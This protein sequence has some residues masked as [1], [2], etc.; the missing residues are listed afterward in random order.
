MHRI[1]FFAQIKWAHG[2]PEMIAELLPKYRQEAYHID[3]SFAKE[4]LAE[5]AGEDDTSIGSSTS[6]GGSSLVSKL[7][8]LVAQAST[9]TEWKPNYKLKVVERAKLADEKAA[10]R[11]R[12]HDEAKGFVEHLKERTLGPGG[13]TRYFSSPN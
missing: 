8:V 10:A 7:A 2:H 6:S 11:E 13:A 1:I 12:R 3:S 5:I 9:D 4:S